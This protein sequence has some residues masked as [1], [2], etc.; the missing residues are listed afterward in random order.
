MSDDKAP[1][2]AEEQKVLDA[3]KQAE[4]TA[5]DIEKQEAA[6][7]YGAE[8]PDGQLSMHVKVHAP[9]NTYYDGRAFSISAEN[10]T[11]PFDILPKHH[12]FITLLSA[13][14]IVV[15]TLKKG[16]QKI[17]ISGGLMHVKADEVIVFLDV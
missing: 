15:R 6:E 17:T 9:F 3:N 11:G 16:D 1:A 4:Q 2:P 10:A 8:A 13:C 14:E 5:E 12:S 7:E